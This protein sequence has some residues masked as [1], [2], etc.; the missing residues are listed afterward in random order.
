MENI[1]VRN[2]F[3]A[4]IS[5]SLPDRKFS[6]QWPARGSKVP[7]DRETLDELM[8]NNGFRYMIEHGMLFIEDMQYKIDAYLEPEGAVEP[9]N[10]VPLD[11][12]KIKRM[13]TVMP[14]IDFKAEIAKLNLDQIN[15][16]A[17][18]AIEHR[19][20]DIDKNKIILR[21]C[22]RDVIRSI[23]LNDADKE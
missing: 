10:L 18:Y 15:I 1:I 6:R 12:A 16:V 7:I 21:A 8:Y 4:P 9:V 20:S 22:G 3:N 2:T 19:C 17:D 11:E 13:V 14:L 23:Q 5:V